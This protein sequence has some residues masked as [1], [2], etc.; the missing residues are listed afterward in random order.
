MRSTSM[1]LWA[2]AHVVLGAGG[3]LW[4]QLARGALWT[5][6]PSPLLLASAWRLPLGSLLTLGLAWLTVRGTRLLVTQTAWAAQLHLH[7]RSELLGASS[8]QMV[9]LAGLSACSEELLFRAALGPSLGFV[10]ASALFGLIHATPRRS[11]L[12]RASW[13][14]GLG[15]LLSALYLASGT[16][17]A[18]I[19]A[20]WLINYEN[21]QYICNYDP[22][23][24]DID[25]AQLGNIPTSER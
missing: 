6:P 22:T 9:L 8:S 7:L 20:H 4:A 23:P 3:M 11:Y 5:A 25:R 18:P 14:F 19:A 16:L 10:T 15:L 1:W 17:L 12:P 24:L 2:A 21:M 13:A